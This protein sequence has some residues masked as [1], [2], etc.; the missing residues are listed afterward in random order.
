[1]EYFATQL[2]G[3]STTTYVALTN[4]S[5]A[6]APYRFWTKKQPISQ[7]F[8]GGPERSAQTTL[9][10]PIGLFSG[11]Q[12]TALLKLATEI[13]PISSPRANKNKVLLAIKKTLP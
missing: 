7:E 2:S 1:M 6:A 4:C 5:H 3:D 9:S 10:Q 8:Q 12:C 11:F 13:V